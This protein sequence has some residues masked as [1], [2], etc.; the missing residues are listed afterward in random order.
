MYLLSLDASDIPHASDGERRGRTTLMSWNTG[1]CTTVGFRA[2]E[3][4]RQKDVMMNRTDGTI[5]KN[6][7]SNWMLKS[8]SWFGFSWRTSSS[9]VL[10]GMLAVQ[11]PLRTEVDGFLFYS[12]RSYKDTRLKADV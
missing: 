4:V 3:S 1:A 11:T 2:W 9:P 12:S 8:K 6:S 10:K 5:E 7:C